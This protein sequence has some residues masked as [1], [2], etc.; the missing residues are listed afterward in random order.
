M[1]EKIISSL[2]FPERD[3]KMQT[4]ARARIRRSGLMRRSIFLVL[5]TRWSAGRRSHVPQQTNK[6]TNIY[7]PLSMKEML[8]NLHFPVYF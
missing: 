2:K 7:Y 1:K 4:Q 8:S 5:D 3:S 6:Q